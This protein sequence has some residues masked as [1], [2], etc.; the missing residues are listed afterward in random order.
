VLRA[1]IRPESEFQRRISCGELKIDGDQT[2]L[3]LPFGSPAASKQSGLGPSVAPGAKSTDDQVSQPGASENVMSCV[4]PAASRS[5]KSNGLA[6]LVSLP[7]SLCIVICIK[8]RWLPA[9]GWMNMP[10]GAFRLRPLMCT[11]RLKALAHGFGAHPVTGAVAGTV[12]FGVVAGPALANVVP[13][14]D[15][16]G[17]LPDVLPP[18]ALPS[19]PTKT[20]SPMSPTQPIPPLRRRCPFFCGETVEWAVAFGTHWVPFQ[21]WAR[22]GESAPGPCATQRVPSQ[23]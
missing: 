6:F 12:L 15:A 21:I 11:V 19:I 13:P 4:S 2:R 23:R 20:R 9:S 22:S 16:L 10:R 5:L 18:S 7:P 14:P 1:G 3:R 8:T 17:F